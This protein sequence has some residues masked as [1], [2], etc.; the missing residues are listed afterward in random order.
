MK[1]FCSP[2]TAPKRFWEKVTNCDDP[3]SCWEWTGSIRPNGEGQIWVGTNNWSSHRYSWV[4]HHGPIPDGLCV[5]HHCDN[6]RCVNPA[7]LFLGT[8]KDNSQDMSKK[9]RQYKQ[10][11]THCVHGHPFD[12]KNTR[13]YRGTRTCR[14]CRRIHKNEAYHRGF[15][16]ESNAVKTH[17][18]RGHPFNVP[19]TWFDKFGGRRC[20]TCDIERQRARQLKLKQQLL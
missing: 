16:Y 3:L 6:R 2:I 15:K 18:A 7:H 4:L 5:C 19:N 14:E 20:R 8:K 13:W 9:K 12:E 17:C 11:A 1:R 10:V